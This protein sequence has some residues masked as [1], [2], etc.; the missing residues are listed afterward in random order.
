[1]QATIFNI[2]TSK[3]IRNDTNAIAASL[4]KNFGVGFG[5]L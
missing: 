2:L 3:A 5:W 1:V 4:D